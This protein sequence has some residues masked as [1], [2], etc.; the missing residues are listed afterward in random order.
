M[1]N[2]GPLLS[3]EGISKSFPGVQALDNVNFE[4]RAGEVNVLLGE[5]GAGKS[6]LIKILSGAYQK[7]EGD[8]YLN[9]QSIDIA[10]PHRARELGIATTYQELELIPYLSVA[11]NIFLGNEHRKKTLGMTIIDWP[12]TYAGARRLFDELG[13]SLKEHVEIVLKA[14]QEI[15]EQLGL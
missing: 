5:N 13:I 2:N 6:T 3:M 4:L 8:I 12:E 15:P 7:D 9:G 1:A 10:N 14:M 11:E